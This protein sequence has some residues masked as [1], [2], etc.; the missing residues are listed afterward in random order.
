MATNLTVYVNTTAVD[1]DRGTSP[2]NYE[3]VDLSNDKLIFSAGSSAVAD[4]LDTP[5]NTELNEAATI[6]QPTPVEIDKLFLLDVSDVGVELKEIDLYGSTDT[7]YVI[8]F[9]LD[10]ATATE[11]TLEAW[12]DNTHSTANLNVLGVGTP[13]ASMIKAVLTTGGSPGAS[14]SGTAIAGGSAPNVLELNGGGG[15]FGSA[16]EIY[17]NLQVVIPGAYSTPFTETPVLTVRYTF[18]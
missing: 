15:A 2:G 7:Q 12:D 1:Q 10:D 5:T 18:V 14:W 13:S 6:I 9:S 16:T 11:P 3:Q 4:G 8:N 17:V